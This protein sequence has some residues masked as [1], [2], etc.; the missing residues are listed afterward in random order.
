MKILVGCTVSFDL[1]FTRVFG[2]VV[3]VHEKT[4]RVRPFIPLRPGCA[5]KLL[6]RHI[7]KHAVK[8]EKEES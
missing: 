2:K 7:E 3:T 1:G 6:K 5:E 4:I 8:I